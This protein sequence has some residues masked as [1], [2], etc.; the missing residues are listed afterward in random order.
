MKTQTPRDPQ[1]TQN[2]S[3]PSLLYMLEEC[4]AEGIRAMRGDVPASERSDPTR[5]FM[6]LAKYLGY[7]DKSRTGTDARTRARVY[8]PEIDGKQRQ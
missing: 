6:R 8:I 7:M 2:D 5:R 4:V 1:G 3:S